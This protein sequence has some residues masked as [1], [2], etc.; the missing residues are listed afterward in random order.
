M[1]TMDAYQLVALESWLVNVFPDEGDI[2]MP[3]KDK[4][5]MY[6]HAQTSSNTS[7]TTWTWPTYRDRRREALRTEGAGYGSDGSLYAW[8]KGSWPGVGILLHDLCAIDVDDRE[9]AAD[10]ERRFPVLVAPTT[11]R[12]DTRRGRHYFFRRSSRCERYGYYDGAGQRAKGIDF[13]SRCST[14]TRGFIETAPSA[15]KVWVVAPW[16]VTDIPE[17]PDDLLHAVAL[18]RHRVVAAV[19]IV[20]HAGATLEIKD[21]VLLPRCAYFEPFFEEDDLLNRTIPIPCPFETKTMARL[22]S[23]L[24]TMLDRTRPSRPGWGALLSYVPDLDILRTLADFLGV[25]PE[26]RRLLWHEDAWRWARD[27]LELGASWARQSSGGLGAMGPLLDVGTNHHNADGPARSLLDDRWLL[28]DVLERPKPLREFANAER[29]WSQLPDWVAELLKAHPGRIVVAGGWA[30]GAASAGAIPEGDDIDLFVVGE[31]A[32]QG[33][34]VE[35]ALRLAREESPHAMSMRTGAAVTISTNVLPDDVDSA[36]LVQIILRVYEGGVRTVLAGFDVDPAR[37]AIWWDSD[38]DGPVLRAPACW[39]TSMARR[40]FFIDAGRWNSSSVTRIFKYYNKGFDV[41]LPGLRRSARRCSSQHEEN[42]DATSRC[43]DFSAVMEIEA[44]VQRLTAPAYR[45]ADP[46]IGFANARP[47]A[48]LVALAMSRWM[49]RRGSGG[50]KGAGRGAGGQGLLAAS[51]YDAVLGIAAGKGVLGWALAS[52]AS[53]MKV[54]GLISW[55]L[56]SGPLRFGRRQFS[57]RGGDQDL[58]D[59]TRD[60]LAQHLQW[61]RVTANG[62]V[63]QGSFFRRSARLG[64]VHD[65]VKL[66]RVDQNAVR[67]TRLARLVAKAF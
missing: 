56:P 18:P 13:K 64:R 45:F 21:D 53:W 44:E 30:L 10:L 25:P 57:E 24:K 34:V 7:N 32:A 66:A 62:G 49:R 59:L 48:D 22:W 47:P 6:A 15:G 1:Q 26:A 43:T 67:E 40:A 28:C 20:D 27:V 52:L 33:V 63:A 4:H 54:G 36:K 60:E 58:F 50:R 3:C 19:N 11:P 5:P 38:E 61:K 31:D 65:P 16:T 12:E 37:I 41:F 14:G 35:D 55:A 29:A 23:L 51:D 39:F 42:D 2:L 8:P 17:I 46:H 9:M